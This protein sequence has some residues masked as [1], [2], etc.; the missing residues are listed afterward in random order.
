MMHIFVNI[1]KVLNYSVFSL[2]NQTMIKIKLFLIT[3]L[4]IL[5]GLHLYAQEN[6]REVV[7]NQINGL[8]T[9]DFQKNLANVPQKQKVGRNTYAQLEGY[10]YCGIKFSYEQRGNNLKYEIY[11]FM[12]PSQSWIRDKNNV[13]TLEHEQAH[14]NIAEIYSRKLKYDLRNEWNL[15]KAKKK[16]KQMFKSLLKKQAAFDKDHH[17]E[18]GVER[19]WEIWISDQLREL[20]QYADK[21]INLRR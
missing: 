6:N 21:S 8:T 1:R 3:C 20:N 18:V 9:D 19:K 14:F 5:L 4:T 7:W 13:G 16:Y 12:E 10:I 15:K 11:S 2:V 17:G